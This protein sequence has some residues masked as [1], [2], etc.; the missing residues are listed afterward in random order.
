[1]RERQIQPLTIK[2]NIPIDLKTLVSSKKL[3]PASPIAL[4]VELPRSSLGFIADAV[5]AIHFIQGDVMT[6][7]KASGTVGHPVFNG[8]AALD[9]SAV[10]AQDVTL[11]VV[12]DFQARLVFN[13][14]QLRFERF[15]GDIGGGKFSV[16]GRVDF[17][18]LLNPTLQLAAKADNV[19]ALR[20]ENIT[21]RVN[22]DVK[23]TGPLAA[24]TVAGKIGLTKSR[25]LKDID[26]IPL[27]LPGQPPPATPAESEGE[28]NIS[29]P[30]PPISNWKFDLA[31]KT[32]DPFYVSGNLAAGK[33]TVDMTLQGTG[34]QPL[35]GGYVTV[36][37]LAAT[38]PFSRLEIDNGNVSFTRGP[39]VESRPQP[40]GNFHRQQLS[41]YDLYLRPRE[42][43][44]RGILE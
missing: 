8:V 38:L 29:I 36:D 28:P 22:A 24:A 44:D 39:A 11:P 31:I 7:I 2:G 14:K 12:R 13:E 9:I 35:L 6:D 4:A 37:H 34:L 30:T 19:L 33:A 20:D 42:V 17:A 15:G 10:R 41:D 43:A 16:D 27:N 3:D 1:M 25:Y 40:D 21:A 32:D 5:P 26:I 18:T 23:I